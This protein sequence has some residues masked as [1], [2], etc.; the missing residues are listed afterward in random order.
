MKC[1]EESPLVILSV[2]VGPERQSAAQR[3]PVILY[4]GV[5]KCAAESPPVIL[6]VIVE[7]S[8]QVCSRKSTTYFVCDC[9]A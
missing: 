1:A 3:L 2:S 4:G 9:G 8:D 5:M 6:C 7:P